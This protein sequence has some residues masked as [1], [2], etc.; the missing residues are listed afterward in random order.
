MT[1]KTPPTLAKAGGEAAAV[2]DL[3]DAVSSNK[4]DRQGPDEDRLVATPQQQ[5]VRQPVVEEM[6]SDGRKK[7]N[8]KKGKN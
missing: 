8:K 5:Q 6:W 7:F 1:K 3:A 4:C 2:V